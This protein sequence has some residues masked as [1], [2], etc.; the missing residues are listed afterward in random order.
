MFEFLVDQIFV[1]VA[2]KVFQHIVSIFWGHK[3]CSSPSRHISVLFIQSLFSGGMKR[4]SISVQLYI[5]SYIDDVL[6]INN[7]E[8]Y[9]G[10]M[11]PTELET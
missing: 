6:F 11:Y 10:Q 5:Y 2:T 4:G 7:P 9:L 3:L 8:K 1:V